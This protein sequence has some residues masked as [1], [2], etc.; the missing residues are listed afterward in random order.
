MLSIAVLAGTWHLIRRVA[1][2][3]ETTAAAEPHQGLVREDA[4]GP[5]DQ[6]KTE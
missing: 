5:K 4:P 6:R 3:A 1:T 2:R